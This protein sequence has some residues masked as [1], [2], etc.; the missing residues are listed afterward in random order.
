MVMNKIID[1]FPMSKLQL[2]MIFQSESGLSDS[3]HDIFSY[4]IKG[5]LDKN[6]MNAAILNVVKHN[7]LLR[8]SYDL[9]D[10]S[11]PMQL[12]YE[13]DFIE[14]TIKFENV[15]G[16]VDKKDFFEKWA[17]KE[18]ITSFN[19][20]E[21]SSLIRFHIHD[22]EDGYF[23]FSISFHHSLMDGYSMA[24]C[25]KQ[26]FKAYNSD[27]MDTL[28][29]GGT[30]Y[31]D[32]IILE[33][34]SI[35][36]ESQQEFWR[37]EVSNLEINNLTYQVE[38]KKS[39]ILKKTL[40]LSK[41]KYFSIKETAQKASVPMKS[42]FLAAYLRLLKLITAESN[43]T[44]GLI[45]NGRPE[46][47]GFDTALGLFLNTIPFA[48]R[49]SQKT[50][51][52]LIQDVYEKEIELLK[53][54]RFPLTE[55]KKFSASKDLFETTFNYID[56]SG[57]LLD[58]ENDYEAQ[59]QVEEIFSFEKTDI[60]LMFQVNND[61][62]TNS[63]ELSFTYDQSLFSAKKVQDLL[64]FYERIIDDIINN[65]FHK[66]CNNEVILES[67]IYSNINAKNIEESLLSNMNPLKLQEFV[68]VRNDELVPIETIGEFVISVASEEKLSVKGEQLKFFGKTDTWYHTGGL[69]MLDYE[70]KVHYKGKL[71]SEKL[72]QNRITNFSGLE[73]FAEETVDN[74]VDARAF[75]KR[76]DNHEQLILVIFGDIDEKNLETLDN[77]IEM[78]FIQEPKPSG[79]LVL[80]ASQRIKKEKDIQ[81]IVNNNEIISFKKITQYVMPS[82]ELESFLSDILVEV[83]NINHVGVFD[84]VFE[85]GCDSILALQIVNKINDRMDVEISIQEFYESENI[86][87]L[88]QEILNKLMEKQDFTESQAD[89]RG[90]NN[91][92]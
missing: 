16:I 34:T 47:K 83:L 11:E 21:A 71:R 64:S 26:I 66:V 50:W 9:S 10:F 38:D 37:N 55:I 75:I 85:L 20:S 23:M 60:P 73:S 27:N 51:L 81:E 17:D 49:V 36:D 65:L 74:I 88:S 48:V 40:L 70:G 45:T 52:E 44:I 58:I 8:A 28:S 82:N 46:K 29:Y 67:N 76:D 5:F 31:K 18:K 61:A 19:W 91:G 68:I 57:M 89:N 42:I 80:E 35:A 3:Y 59:I 53:Y 41:E 72:F 4:V 79:Y 6:K 78:E 24:L 54:R 7:E 43:I 13:P 77:K 84:N 69:A 92:N 87:K 15:K 90:Y 39:S 2:G 30:S 86:K 33:K 14:P 25:V 22:F 1:G 56:F 12:I 62:L 63:F 32:Y